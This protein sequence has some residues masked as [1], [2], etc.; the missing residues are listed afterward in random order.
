M[1][2]AH[3]PSFL[4]GADGS[5]PMMTSVLI[6][7]IL[8]VVAAGAF[9]LHLHSLPERMAHSRNSQHMELVAVLC[10]LALFT[11]NNLFW[12]AA[13]V[14]VF[15]PVPDV[16]T[17]LTSIARSLR[18]LSGQAVK[19]LEPARAAAHTAASSHHGEGRPAAGATGV[20]KDEARS[21]PVDQVAGAAG[22]SRSDP[23]GEGAAAPAS[24]GKEG[25]SHA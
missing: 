15:L 19:P 4:P 13:L 24:T 14:L 1:A 23:G 8:I 25:S 3:L 17:P 11:H 16:V 2:S 5:D 22:Q 9:Y 10:L 21:L 7:L 18:R 20:L 12:V 6:G